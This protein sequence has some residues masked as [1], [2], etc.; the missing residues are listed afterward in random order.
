VHL[1]IGKRQHEI[2]QEPRPGTGS[3]EPRAV[4]GRPVTE[5]QL[6]AK[7][8]VDRLAP[9]NE[10][11]AADVRSLDSLLSHQRRADLVTGQRPFAIILGCSD[12]RV[13]AESVFDSGLGDLFVIRVASPVTSL[14]SVTLAGP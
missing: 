4:K 7:E 3:P 6:T 11:F 8:A 13:P 9:G 1:E 5:P 14:R 10:R 2:E 12:S